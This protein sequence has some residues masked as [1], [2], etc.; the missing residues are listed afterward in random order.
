MS[1]TIRFFKFYHHY[2]LHKGDAAE[3]SQQHGHTTYAR[4]YISISIHLSLRLLTNATEGPTSMNLGL[5]SA[6]GRLKIAKILM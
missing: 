2:W 5:M 1:R 4:K 3:A 6:N